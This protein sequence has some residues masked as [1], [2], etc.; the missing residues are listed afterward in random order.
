[1]SAVNLNKSPDQWVQA[2][3]KADSDLRVGKIQTVVVAIIASLVIGG[4]LAGGGLIT[5]SLLKHANLLNVG[6]YVA[7]PCAVVGGGLIIVACKIKDKAQ[8]RHQMM[9][10]AEN[11]LLSL[12][13]AVSYQDLLGLPKYDP[14]YLQRYGIMEEATARELY[15]TIEAFRSGSLNESPAR[16]NVTKVGYLSSL[17]TSNRAP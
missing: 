10:H 7:V 2:Q 13:G 1:M 12:K 16:F 3:K 5:V 14:R 17:A 6:C 11:F 8:Q 4:A 15:Q 9:E